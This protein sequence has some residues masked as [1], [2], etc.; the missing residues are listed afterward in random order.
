MH[1][2][3]R[4]RQLTENN[5]LIVGQNVDY[6]GATIHGRCLPGPIPKLETMKQIVKTMMSQTEYV[7]LHGDAGSWTPRQSKTLNA[8]LPRTCRGANS[9]S[10][11]RLS[12]ASDFWSCNGFFFAWYAHLGNLPSAAWLDHNRA[13]RVSE[14]QIAKWAS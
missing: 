10:A 8:E 1:S 12:L 3:Y 4:L 9:T 11:L 2:C 13:L 14:A 7:L 6:P 5:F